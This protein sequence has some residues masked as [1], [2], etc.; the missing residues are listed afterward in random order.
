MG[1]RGGRCYCG[2]AAAALRA[3]GS[4][5]QGRRR[6]PLL[7]VTASALPSGAGGGRGRHEGGGVAPTAGVDGGCRCCWRSLRAP[8]AR[9]HG[10]WWWGGDWRPPPAVA[11][12]GG[13]CGRT[14]PP[15]FWGGGGVGCGDLRGWSWSSDRRSGG[16]P[17]RW[18]R[19]ALPRWRGGGVG[20][21]KRRRAAA[22]RC[23]VGA[24]RRRRSRAPAYGRRGGAGVVWW[25]QRVTVRAVGEWRTL[26]AWT[27]NSLA[28][29]PRLQVTGHAGR[30]RQGRQHGHPLSK[31][32]S[33]AAALT[34]V[35]GG[36]G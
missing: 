34:L 9:G 35:A 7:V 1:D 22:A 3:H 14:V 31:G 27:R 4:S 33:G 28:A 23:E 29:Q 5:R 25:R 32:M 11:G 18:R 16:A 36:A 17:C 2:G 24:P 26:P 20:E 30:H 12:G 13:R 6:P 21:S 10:C 19:T 15:F 8:A